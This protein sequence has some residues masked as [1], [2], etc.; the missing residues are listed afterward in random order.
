MT[1][2]A[3]SIHLGIDLG[4]TK[5]ALGLVNSSGTILSRTTFPSTRN[6]FEDYYRCLLETIESFLQSADLNPGEIDTIGIG[7]AGQIELSTGMIHHSPN[8]NW[9]EAPLGERLKSQYPSATVTIDNDVRAATIG[10]YLF[11]FKKRPEIYLNV[12]LG[13]G[14]GSG[15]IINDRILRGSSNCAGE[16]GLTSI[17]YD[18]PKASCGN[19]GIFEYY[20]SG[21]ALERICREQVQKEIQEGS[22]E[23]SKS[24]ASHFGSPEFVKGAEI[25]RLA[26]EGNRAAKKLIEQI[27]EFI[28]MGLANIVNVLNPDT[29][30]Y[31]GGLSEVG[32]LLLEP[33]ERTLR[34]RAL[35]PATEHLRLQPASLGNDAG[36][37]GSAW[38]H[39]VDSKGKI[40][41]VS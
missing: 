1:E 22:S 26:R 6:D 5:T 25:S 21:T 31:G 32:P 29:L 8:L 33:M 28:G 19:Y 2:K 14:I 27:G 10:E 20:A 4:G 24:L 13:T 3:K 34:E 17:R 30:T 11:G 23:D 16:V 38:L 12:F 36:I 9:N 18:G 35:P 39:L 37:I 7:C 15:I 41:Q 40:G